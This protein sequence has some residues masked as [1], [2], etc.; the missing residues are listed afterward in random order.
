MIR[1]PAPRALVAVSVLGL[2]SEERGSLVRNQLPGLHVVQHAGLLPWY[3]QIELL[4]VE[5]VTDR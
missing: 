2:R 4:D 3:L 5:T 1:E